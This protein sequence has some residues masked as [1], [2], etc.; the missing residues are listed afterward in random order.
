MSGKI[1]N[2]GIVGAGWVSGEHIK[3]FQKNP[4]SRVV[5]IMSRTEEKAA[6][7]AKE[8]D[9]KCNTYSDYDKMLKMDKLDIVVI[10]TPHHLH[11][12][13]SVKAIEAGKHVLIEKPMALTLEDLARERDAV[14]KHNVK[15]LV[16]FVLRWNP[17]FETVKRLMADDALGKVYYAEADYI[18]RVGEWYSGYNWVRTRSMGGSALLAAGCHAVDA[19]RWFVGDV[20]EVVAYSGGYRKDLEYDGTILA[21][22]RFENGAI[23]KVSANFDC[24]L[25]YTFNLELFGD[26][27]TIRNNKIYS[28]WKF[29]GQTESIEIQTVMP[30][31]A[32]VTHHPFEAEINHFIECLLTGSESHANVEDAVKTHE[33]CLAADISAEEHRP[34]KLP[35]I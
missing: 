3:A 20:A 19:L 32:E 17:F 10:C 16:S 1:Y 13:Q 33:V 15:T 2:V 30:D 7:K 12:D 27:G 22:L 5:A 14:R 23:G 35:L 11:A 26:K 34:V 31:T 25:P 28:P 9:L 24:V 18:S 8:Y 6:A 29:P 21:M 4:H